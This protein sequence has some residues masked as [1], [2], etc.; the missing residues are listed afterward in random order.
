MLVL[1]F[2]FGIGGTLTGCNPIVNRF[3]ARMLERMDAP[4]EPVK[5][6]VAHPIRPDVGLSVLRVG[7]ATV[8]I[9]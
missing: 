5:H 1:L 8:L 4:I 6:R 9:P 7:H 2:C 3:A